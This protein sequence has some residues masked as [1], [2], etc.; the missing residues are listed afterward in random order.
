MEF[1]RAFQVPPLK[2]QLNIR[3]GVMLVGSCFTDHLGNKLQQHRFS[4]LQNPHGILFNPV[5]LA[6]SVT[7]YIEKKHYNKN[8]LFF[9]Q[10]WWTSW[11]HH[12]QYSHAD[13]EVLLEMINRS[14]DE[15]HLFLQKAKWLVLTVGSAWV[16]QLAEGSI[17]ANC[18]KVPTDKFQKRLLP[19]EEVLAVL[20][21]MVHRL[22]MYNPGLRII[23]TISPVRHLRDG[24]VENNRSKAVLIQAVHHLVEKFEGLFYFPAYELIIDDLRDYRFYAEDMVHPNYLATSYVW[25]KFSES[26]IDEE[27]RKFIKEIAPINAALAHKP[28]QPDSNAHKL[29]RQ[30]QVEKLL[31]LQSSYPFLH[32]EQ[33][34]SFFK[35]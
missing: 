6:R 17:V 15:A 21:N 35:D 18:H 19:V 33:E 28:F 10:E 12:S 27:S 22:F 7:S 23:F 11:D 3:H 32:F 4:T 24:F 25:E 13:P 14:Q 29:F 16:Y 30:K 2:E 8:D 31:Q 5:S 9:Q 26:C 20:D 1:R 34:I